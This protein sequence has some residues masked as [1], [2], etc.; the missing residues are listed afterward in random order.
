M[1]IAK[2]IQ[3]CQSVSQIC[4]ERQWLSSTAPSAKK[5]TIQNQV[6]I[7][8]QT[9]PISEQDFRL[10]LQYPHQYPYYIIQHMLFMVHPEY[11]PK[12]PTSQFVARLYGFKIHPM[13]YQL[14]QVNKNL[15]SFSFWNFSIWAY[16]STRNP[17]FFSKPS[18]HCSLGILKIEYFYFSKP[19]KISTNQK[20]YKDI[21]TKHFAP[22]SL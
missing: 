21:E 16:K 17:C 19:H 10:V 8:T 7:I 22:E 15:I 13:A 14:Q 18:L 12:R 9:E 20:W 4:Q 1:F 6:D 2:I 5:Y 11:R 3:C